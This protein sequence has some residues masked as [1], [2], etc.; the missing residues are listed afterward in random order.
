MEIT[1]GDTAAKIVTVE[2]KPRKSRKE[3]V[4]RSR[5]QESAQAV[6]SHSPG[7]EE[8]KKK[9]KS[10]SVRR[11]ETESA[12]APPT[13]GRSMIPR[14]ASR[15][16]PGPARP[17]EE[18]EP[19]GGDADWFAARRNAHVTSRNAKHR[20]DT[21]D[22]PKPAGAV[23]GEP[24]L[25]KTF[26]VSLGNGCTK[27]GSVTLLNDDRFRNAETR[28]SD[29][30]FRKTE[31]RESDDYFSK[32]ET[33]E[34]DDYSRNTETRESEDYFSKTE[35]HKSDDYSRNTETHESDDYFRNAETHESDDYF[36]NAETRESDDYFS[37]TET[38]DLERKAMEM[39]GDTDTGGAEGLKGKS[40][41]TYF[42]STAESGSA[43]SRKTYVIAHDGK[44]GRASA[45]C[46]RTKALPASAENEPAIEERGA[47]DPGHAEEPAVAETSALELPVDRP[48]TPAWRENGRGRSWGPLAPAR[49]RRGTLVT[50]TV[51][52]RRTTLPGRPRIRPSSSR[53]NPNPR[54]ARRS[55]APE[56]GR[57]RENGGMTP[58]LRGRRGGRRGGAAVTKSETS[59]RTSRPRGV[60]ARP[61]GRPPD[62]SQRSCGRS[63]RNTGA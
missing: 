31:T 12:N 38:C 41:K 35:T 22:A 27:A 8:R 62:R 45:K 29:D 60:P 39:P 30:Y 59:T 25:R 57:R 44:P 34:S 11:E 2:T 14:P 37:K 49:A 40:R 58:A 61:V 23:P 9:K 19:A 46:R 56:R 26:I 33:H 17:A 54:G 52:L 18:E 42:I 50:R 4:A 47:G 53:R 20:R 21:R 32:T 43:A 24:N 10:S 36:R 48:G 13:Q 1:L 16:P 7:K 28:E 51:P 63:N 5:K 3:G 6:G 55:A 15:L